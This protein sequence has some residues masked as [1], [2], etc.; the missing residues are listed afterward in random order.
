MATATETRSIPDTLQRIKLTKPSHGMVSLAK[1]TKT[2]LGYPLLADHV[3]QP[4]QLGRALMKLD[5]AILSNESVERYKLEMLRGARRKHRTTYRMRYKVLW[6]DTPI[7]SYT[8]PI[9]EFVLNK[10]VQVKEA[11][12]QAAFSV[13]HL[14]VRKQ[15]RVPVLARPTRRDW[16]PFLKVSHGSGNK[17]E[18]Y[19][20]EVWDEPKFEDKL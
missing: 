6:K 1:K 5:I 2:L 15:K 16:D 10:A 18:T 14:N 20:I 12:P 7:R 8:S 11:V 9:P 13:E 3:L 4:G 19:Y 17:R